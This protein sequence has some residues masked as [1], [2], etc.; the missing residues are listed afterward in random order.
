MFPNRANR[1]MSSVDETSV[2][3]SGIEH[4]ASFFKAIVEGAAGASYLTTA[5]ATEQMVYVSPQVETLFGLSQTD[6]MRRPR[7]WVDMIHADDVG[8]VLHDLATAKSTGE[9]FRSEYRVIPKSRDM[10]WVEHRLVPITGEDGETLLLGTLTEIS[11]RKQVE[12]ALRELAFLDELTGLYN[13]RGFLGLAEQ[14]L[15]LAKRT[16][17][18]ALLLLVDVDDLKMINDSHGHHL[19]DQALRDMADLLRHSFRG[20]DILARHGGDEFG[21]W[22]VEADPESCEM[23]QARLY[24]NLETMIEA[25]ERPYRLSFSVGAVYF[26]PTRENPTLRALMERADGLMYARKRGRPGI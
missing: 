3:G 18:G 21:I 1:T 26:D 10:L 13:L 24:R 20:T 2:L 19:G 7:L 8:R 11:F 12:D 16:G 6:W 22:A 25:T 23:L 17:R 4:E 9:P 5:G 15:T 14:Q